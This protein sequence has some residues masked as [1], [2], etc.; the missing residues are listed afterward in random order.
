[1]SAPCIVEYEC[2]TLCQVAVQVEPLR[3]IDMLCLHWNQHVM[4]TPSTLSL[5]FALILAA[6][7]SQVDLPYQQLMTEEVH[8]VEVEQRIFNAVISQDVPT[9]TVELIHS[10][11]LHSCQM[12]DEGLHIRLS[13]NSLAVN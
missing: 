1:M 8:I 9:L 7:L 11:R 12:K 4:N 6:G 3:K 13:S 2:T 10:C 5:R